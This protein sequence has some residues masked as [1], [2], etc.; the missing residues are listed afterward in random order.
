M[1]DNAFQRRRDIE[2]MLLSGKKLTTSEMMKMYGVGRKAIRRDF[3]IIGEEL[4]V[5]TK[6]GY[7]GGYLLADG[8]GQHQN[9]LTQEQL[10]CLEKNAFHYLVKPID[11]EKFSEVFSRAWKD[12]SVFCEQ[13]KKYI[14]VNTSSLSDIRAV[15]NSL[16]LNN[17]SYYSWTTSSGSRQH[18]R[19]D[20]AD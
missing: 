20:R 9:T 10:E 8:V 6:Q 3:D 7:D 19:T 16:V 5:I 15:N 12:V 18:R 17:K 2:R 1:K 14:I 4:P 13:E 11:E